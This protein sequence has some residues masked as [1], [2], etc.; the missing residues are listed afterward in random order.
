VPALEEEIHV[1]KR[2]VKLG[3]AHVSKRVQETKAQQSVPVFR[4]PMVVEHIPPDQYNVQ[5]P[6][7]P[8]EIIVPVLEEQLVV[9]K[10]TLVN[11]YLR[12]HCERVQRQRVVRDT[13]RREIVEVTGPQG[14]TSTDGTG[15]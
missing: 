13:V 1:R 6:T 15:G 11:E 5:A 2:P 14:D 8:N 7:N 10:R 9:E 4:E 12:V 3:T